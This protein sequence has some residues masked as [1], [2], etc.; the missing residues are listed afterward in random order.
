MMKVSLSL[1]S[2]TMGKPFFFI[3]RQSESARLS[4]FGP[5]VRSTTS[6][7]G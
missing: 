2:K 4:I 5:F 1:N 3:F 6:N 7:R